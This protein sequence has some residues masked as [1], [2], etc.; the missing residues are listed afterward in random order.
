VASSSARESS[1]FMI[2]S[3]ALPCPSSSTACIHLHRN[4]QGL[5]LDNL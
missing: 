4:T 2:W 3:W 1:T 5:L